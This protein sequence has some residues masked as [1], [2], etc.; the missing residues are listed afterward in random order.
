[1]T[2]VGIDAYNQSVTWDVAKS[3]TSIATDSDHIPC[4][5]VIK[6]DITDNNHKEQKDIL[7]D[8]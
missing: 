4:V 5:I 7:F 2:A 1:M 3:L 8:T 6:D